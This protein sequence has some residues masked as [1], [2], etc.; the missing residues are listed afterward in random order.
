MT[1]P[2]PR[3]FLRL[4]GCV[5]TCSLMHILGALSPTKSVALTPFKRAFSASPGSA[6]GSL[7]GRRKTGPFPTPNGSSDSRFPASHT[8]ESD[9]RLETIETTCDRPSAEAMLLSA[10]YSVMAVPGPHAA[11]EKARGFQGIGQGGQISIGRNRG[12]FNRR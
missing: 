5:S 10:G 2:I 1:A 11:L 7:G 8:G 6:F 12:I 9:H 3:S 4:F